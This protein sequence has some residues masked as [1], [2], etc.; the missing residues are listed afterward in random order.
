M[1]NIERARKIWNEI[2]R[3]LGS[4]RWIQYITAQLDEVERGAQDRL[5]EHWFGSTETDWGEG[6]R[7]QGFRAARDKAAEEAD[8]HNGCIDRE[9]LARGG[10]CGVT[11]AERIRELKP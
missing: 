1:T 11:I 8:E 7:A 6:I 2:P 9:C 3:D 4:E 10:N 5:K